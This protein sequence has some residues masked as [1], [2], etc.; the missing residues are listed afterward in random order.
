MENSLSESFFNSKDSENRIG[1]QKNLG[2][3]PSVKAERRTFISFTTGKLTLL[4]GKILR[5][6]VLYQVISQQQEEKW[7]KEERVN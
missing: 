6:F 4:S 1:F 2:S 3:L 5:L 7:L